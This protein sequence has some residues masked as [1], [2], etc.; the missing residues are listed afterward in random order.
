MK[1]KYKNVIKPCKICCFCPYGVL[2]EKYPLG[3][4][5][6]KDNCSVFGHIC[7]AFYV[8]EP[9]AEET[10]DEDISEDK[11][12]EMYEEMVPGVKEKI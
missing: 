7:P 10:T 11:F 4:T 1:K 2:A 5:G 6:D 8:A 9:F 3:E 12:K